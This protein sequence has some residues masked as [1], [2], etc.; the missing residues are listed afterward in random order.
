MKG[1]HI[2]AVLLFLIAITGFSF[3]APSVT[4][5]SPVS[6][7]IWTGTHTIDFNV[8]DENATQP[9]VN[10]RLYIYYS[11][12]ANARQ[13][14]IVGDTNVYDGSGVVCADY[15]FVNTT[16]CYYSWTIPST[17]AGYYYIDYNFLPNASTTA[18]VWGSSARFT[19]SQP[20]TGGACGLVSLLPL[21][22]VAVLIIG[23]VMAGMM[24]NGGDVIQAL[25]TLAI[26]AIT[27]LIIF[28]VWAPIQAIV[29]IA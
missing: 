15:N 13:N 1:F 8:I 22:L 7:S 6:T 16:A 14:L 4:S 23:I 5:V 3:A 19:V 21:V 11:T 20:L 27:L 2:I 10:N 17:I 24:F 28:A 29:C 18:Y 25:V 9:H 12:D 26:T